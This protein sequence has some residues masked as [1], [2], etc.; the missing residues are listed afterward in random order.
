MTQDNNTD[1]FSMNTSSSESESLRI[2]QR[3]I[4]LRDNDQR[5][6]D[7]LTDFSR[8]FAQGWKMAVGSC[9]R[10]ALDIKFTDK[11]SKGR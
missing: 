2:L 7:V 9:F 10:D 3:A 11:V 8:G 1:L 6:D 4:A 5:M